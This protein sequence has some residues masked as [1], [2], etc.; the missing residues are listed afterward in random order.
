MMAQHW[1]SVISCFLAERTH[2]LENTIDREVVGITLAQH[3]YLMWVIYFYFLKP[4][5]YIL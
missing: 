1:I 2:I 5:L 4:N 3:L